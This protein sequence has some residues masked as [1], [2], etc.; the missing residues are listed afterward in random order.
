MIDHAVGD[1]SLG[2]W[3][4]LKALKFLFPQFNQVAQRWGYR[5]A[6]D[7]I[8]NFVVLE[9]KNITRVLNDAFGVK[10]VSQSDENLSHFAKSPG[11]FE[12]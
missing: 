2:G 9:V 8:K 7:E 11:S 4:G 12:A 1:N 3:G 5:S 10:F 6:F